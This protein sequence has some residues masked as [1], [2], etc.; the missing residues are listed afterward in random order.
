MSGNVNFTEVQQSSQLSMD[1]GRRAKD[2]IHLEAMKEAAILVRASSPPLPSVM[3]L[4][5]FP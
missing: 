5:L 2:L 4:T 3:F 1:T